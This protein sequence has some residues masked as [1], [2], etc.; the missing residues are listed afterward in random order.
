MTEFLGEVRVVQQAVQ[1][2]FTA[3][4]LSEPY[5]HV[6]LQLYTDLVTMLYH[7]S[8]TVLHI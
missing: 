7:F 2:Q 6:L 1:V 3:S 5:D 8:T 4:F